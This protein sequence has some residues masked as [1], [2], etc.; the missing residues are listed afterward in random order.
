MIREPDPGDARGREPTDPRT[1][2]DEAAE[3]P[4]LQ[5]APP[6]ADRG[7]DEVGTI[8]DLRRVDRPLVTT[9]GASTP[10]R[11]ATDAPAVVT[12]PEPDASPASP[13]HDPLP[14]PSRRSGLADSVLATVAVPLVLLLVTLVA[15]T[16]LLISARGASHR[17][18]ELERGVAARLDADVAIERL[19]AAALA[20]VAAGVGQSVS[21][22]DELARRSS[23]ATAAIDTADGAVPDDLAGAAAADEDARAV[24]AAVD[25]AI[26]RTGADPL[27]LGNE[28]SGLED[29]RVDAAASSA[30]VVE[31]LRS[32]AATESDAGGQRVLAALAVAVLGVL[33]SGAAL[34]LARRRLGRQLDRP[35]RG[36]RG[37]VARIGDDPPAVA[38]VLQGPEELVVLG[39]EVDA[40]ARGVADRLGLLERRAEWGERS[41]MILEALEVA[42]DESGAC[43][44]V[45]EA[46]GIVGD[47]LPGEL[48]LSERGSTRLSSVAASSVAGSPGCPVD[49]VSNCVA[50]RRGQVSV[51]DSSE[52]INACPKL[53]DRAGGACSAACVPV[54][55]GGRQHGVLHVT[56]ADGQP[57]A[58]SVVEQMVTLSSLVGTRL[59]SLRTLESTRHEASTDGLTGLPNRRTLE[60]EVAELLE[61]ST[62][63]VMVLADLDKFKRLNDNFGHEVGDK[64]LQLFAGVLRDNVRGNDV[65]ARLG[66]EEF[67][68]VYPNM[69]VEISV[70]A[71]DR[72]RQALARAVGASRI[73]PFT[74]SFGIAHSAVGGDGDVILRVADAGLLRAKEL[75]GDRAVVADEALAADVF[76]DDPD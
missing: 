50:L 7:D 41:R 48:L 65:V 44:V 54:T 68:L 11:R 42:D 30:A 62:P 20:L 9:S 58:A 17:A 22:P 29:R 27:E 19:N 76:T 45:A 6:P 33:A 75:G 34:L 46:L 12:S 36:L 47:D 51:F 15:T 23:A 61:A 49:V 60:S 40:A 8:V 70:E 28:L 10:A 26:D 57:P 16:G 71:I 18:L 2:D 63:F 73:P 14:V 4:A 1:A 3:S 39:A 13:P 72:L 69:S 31:S 32:A 35:V 24:V 25:E 59:S 66:G 38:S 43:E 64:A 52:S 74:C 21:G 67:V 37:A 55:V 5:L 56:A 53:R